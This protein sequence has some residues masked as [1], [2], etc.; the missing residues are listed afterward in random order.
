ME[1]K[2]GLPRTRAYVDDDAVVIEPSLASGSGDELEH[3]LRLLRLELA[4]VAEGVDMAFGQH[5]QMGLGRRVDVADRDVP[6]PGKDVIPVPDE[7]AEE[8]L[9]RQRG[10]PRR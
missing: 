3:A 8:A 5:E 6:L 7:P 2:D 1:V 10:S 4:D 9:L